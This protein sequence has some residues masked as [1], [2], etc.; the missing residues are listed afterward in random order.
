MWLVFLRIQASVSIPCVPL[1]G[2]YACPC[3]DCFCITNPKE[4]VTSWASGTVSLAL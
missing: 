4:I 2:T 1:H 3:Y